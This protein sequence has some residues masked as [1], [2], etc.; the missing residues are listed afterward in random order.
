MVPKK[1]QHMAPI[2]ATIRNSGSGFSIPDNYFDE[3][4]NS[5]VNKLYV[6]S[7]PKTTGYNIPTDYFEEVENKAIRIKT[8]K[9][10][11]I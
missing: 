7:L 9:N 2:L 3:F 1:L 6:D 4:E 10:E 5:F 11:R 8:V